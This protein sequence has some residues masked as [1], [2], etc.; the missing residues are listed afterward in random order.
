MILRSLQSDM[1]HFDPVLHPDLPEKMART[2]V[3]PDRRK[4]AK[5]NFVWS[6]GQRD[7]RGYGKSAY[8]MWMA[9]AIN[10]GSPGS[11]C[12]AIAMRSRRANR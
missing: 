8:M 3:G 9:K 7:A 4:M 5:V 2:L 12:L 10:S 1:R 11:Q 6:L